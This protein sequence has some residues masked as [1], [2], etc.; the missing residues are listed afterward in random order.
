MVECI[1]AAE[2][3][4][5][6]IRVNG[7]NFLTSGDSPGLDGILRGE[8]RSGKESNHITLTRFRVGEV[9]GTAVVVMDLV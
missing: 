8:S 1:P 9:R 5:R 6:S 7:I 3:G 4:R 2:R